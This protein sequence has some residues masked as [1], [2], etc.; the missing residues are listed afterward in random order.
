MCGSSSSRVDFA[1]REFMLIS[2][3]TT[4][5]NNDSDLGVFGCTGTLLHGP[6]GVHEETAAGASHSAGSVLPI[7]KVVPA[8]ISSAKMA[9][10][11]GANRR[12]LSWFWTDRRVG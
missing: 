12:E 5:V 6:D 11:W 3:P 8:A 2:P 7:R 9:L 10:I 1:M 4:R